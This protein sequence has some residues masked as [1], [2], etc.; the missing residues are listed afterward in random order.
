[1]SPQPY[2]T[3][4]SRRRSPPAF[5]TTPTV[6]ALVAVIAALHG[7]RLLLPAQWSLEL[8]FVA[9]FAPSEF[10]VAVDSLRDGSGGPIDAFRPLILASPLTH[11]FL[12]ADIFH[13]G[14]NLAFL[15]AFGTAVDRYV[16]G[17]RFLALFLLSVLGGAALA[18]VVYLVSGGLVLMVGASGGVSG[19]FGAFVR[20]GLRRRTAAIA[21]FIGINVILAFTG[22]SSF[23]ET[24]AIAWDAHIGGFLT[25]YFLLPLFARGRMPPPTGGLF[26]RPPGG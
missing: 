26:G 5:N 10:L 1:M 8:L 21:I 19:L 11:A 7:V 25:G 22:F 3:Q 16:G 23:D 17:V 9:G 18:L 20:F 15:L 24:R 14:L 13:L 6:V 4:P 2:N 12:H